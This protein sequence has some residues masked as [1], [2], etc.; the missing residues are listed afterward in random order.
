[1]NLDEKQPTTAALVPPERPD[2][3]HNKRTNMN[4]YENTTRILKHRWI[5]CLQGTTTNVYDLLCDKTKGDAYFGAT[6]SSDC[7]LY[8]VPTKT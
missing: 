5:E 4:T 7:F 6:C 1:M 8:P 2:M 3:E